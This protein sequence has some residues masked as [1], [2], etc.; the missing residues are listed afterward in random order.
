[1]TRDRLKIWGKLQEFWGQ[2]QEFG[3]SFNKELKSMQLH[4]RLYLANYFQD[5]KRDL[6]FNQ[7]DE[8][9]EKAKYIEIINK[10]DR[11]EQDYYKRILPFN[12]FENEI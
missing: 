8:I 1:V 4:P 6:T 10:I 11:I 5:L 7:V 12:T 9:N 3:G 2:G